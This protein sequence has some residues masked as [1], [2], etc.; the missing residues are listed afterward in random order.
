MNEAKL[1]ARL[2]RSVAVDYC[3]PCQAF[4]FDGHE[5][6]A[7]TPGA[8]LALFQVIGSNATAPSLDFARDALSESRRA[9]WRVGDTAKCPR[10]NSRLVKTH[11]MQRATR[12]EYLRCPHGHGRLT[13]FYSF[14]REKD[15]IR[16]LT[17]QQIAELKQNVRTINCSNCGAPVDLTQRTDCSHCGS[18]LTM[19]NLQQAENLIAQLRDA[20]QPHAIDP[21]LPLQ[22]ARARRDVEASFAAA[23]RDVV[24][25]QHAAAEGLVGTG[26]AALARWLSSRR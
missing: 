12:F 8:T 1:D 23:N 11:D 14:L 3:V 7:L 2:D 25:F 21:D 26:L 13:S 18:P 16:P 24:W 5:S 6:L 15:F 17:P 22:L 20:N 4:W 10:C 9:E 19:L